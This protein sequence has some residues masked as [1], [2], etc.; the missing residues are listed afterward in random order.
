MKVRLLAV[1][2][3]VV[4]GV[5]AGTSP[6]M[7]KKAHTA[8]AWG[9]Q[10][11]DNKV[12]GEAIHNLRLASDKTNWDASQFSGFV[13]TAATAL[14]KGLTDLAASY[15]NFQYGVVQLSYAGCTTTGATGCL[16]LYAASVPFVATP[17][18]DPTSQ[19]STVTAQ[20]KVPASGAGAGEGG[21]KISAT[22]TVRALDPAGQDAVSTA[23]CR[24]SATQTPP[25]TASTAGYPNLYGT[26]TP[27]PT[28]G[29]LPFTPLRRSPLKPSNDAEQVSSIVGL[30]TDDKKVAVNLLGDDLSWSGTPSTI[31]G[32]TSNRGQTVDVTLSCMYIQNADLKKGGITPPFAS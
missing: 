20:F 5:M 16:A 1:M 29:N 14:Q 15:G 28:Y 32:F 9:N 12:F 25:A 6:A 24:V 27:S 8:S 23:F 11:K 31:G 10:H 19:Q 26:T 18:L 2:A 21:G 13:I 7:A 17:R 4:V 30:T 22:A 3:V